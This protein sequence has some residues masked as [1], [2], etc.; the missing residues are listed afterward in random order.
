MA[1]EPHH[2]EGPASPSSPGALQGLDPGH[3]RRCLLCRWRHHRPNRTRFLI[4]GRAWGGDS[5]RVWEQ[6]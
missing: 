5:G 2:P 3:R 4:F 6:S 1:C